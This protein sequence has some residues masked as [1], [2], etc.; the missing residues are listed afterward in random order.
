MATKQWLRSAVLAC[1]CVLPACAHKS[2]APPKDGTGL[3]TEQLL[4]VARVLEQS[5]DTVRAEQYLRSALKDGADERQI[6]PRLLRLYVADGQLRLAIDVA[7]Q[8]LR[9]EPEDVTLRLFLGA[10]H[11]AVGADAI[12]VQ[13]YERVLTMD[14]KNAEAHFA[15]ASLLHDAGMERDRA[16]QHFR[17]YLE[18]SPHGEHA[19]EARGLLLTEMP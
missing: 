4:E 14:E 19:A 3:T 1:L 9:E 15:L 6:L 10:L 13:Q 8:S 7:E 18:L 16:D 11:T 12:A 17:S 5:G 2:M